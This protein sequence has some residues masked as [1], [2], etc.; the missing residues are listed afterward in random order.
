LRLVV[1]IAPVPFVFELKRRPSQANP[2]AEHSSNNENE[3]RRVQRTF[4]SSAFSTA[5]TV[6]NQDLDAACQKNHT[7]ELG[8]FMA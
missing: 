8:C 5:K 2:A 7:T 1:S 4:R 3:F 6:V